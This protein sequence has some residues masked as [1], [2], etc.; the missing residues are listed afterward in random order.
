MFGITLAL[1]GLFPSNLC[2]CHWP[3]GRAVL[4]LLPLL[5]F[6][7]LAAACVDPWCLWLQPNRAFMVMLSACN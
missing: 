2:A 7:G 3:S 4:L 1:L 5:L 6:A